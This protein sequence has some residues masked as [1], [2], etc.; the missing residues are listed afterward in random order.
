[1]SLDPLDRLDLEIEERRALVHVVNCAQLVLAF[2]D[3]P[4]DDHYSRAAEGAWEILR[5]AIA[6]PALSEL[7]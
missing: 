4:R 2:H 5:S 6:D 1:M 7:A 3:G